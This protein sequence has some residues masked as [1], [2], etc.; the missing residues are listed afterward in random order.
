MKIK[1]VTHN[2]RRSSDFLKN[3]SPKDREQHIKEFIAAC[4][5]RLLIPVISLT[6]HD[7]H[8][9]EIEYEIDFREAVSVKKYKKDVPTV[10]EYEGRRYV[11]D[12]RN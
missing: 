8:Y 9:R 5:S 12:N 11:L 7:K 10:I 4:N 6:K 2:S 3:L 1:G